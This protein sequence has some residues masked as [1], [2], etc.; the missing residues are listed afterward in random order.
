MTT[1]NLWG[2][3]SNL[4][5]IRTP[6]TILKEQAA[7]LNEAT[8]GVVRADVT[9]GGTGAELRHVMNL[10][11]PVLGNYSYLV[12]MVDHNI[13]IYPCRIYSP[14]FPQWQECSNET[15]LQNKLGDVL[16]DQKTRR[17]IESLLSQSQ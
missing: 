2:D 6:K 17:V 9:S 7:I 4:K 12:V 1:P 10:V 11:A 5:T 8:K 15:D 14:V 13:N 3:L 16:T